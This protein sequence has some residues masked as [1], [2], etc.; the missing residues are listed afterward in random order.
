[1]EKLMWGCCLCVMLACTASIPCLLFWKEKD[2]CMQCGNNV[3]ILTATLS[4]QA[5]LC[6]GAMT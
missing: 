3:N 4:V 1:M 6:S 2:I 5:Y